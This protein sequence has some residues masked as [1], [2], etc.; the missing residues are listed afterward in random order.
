MRN[1]F[2]CLVVAFWLGACSGV[3]VY[4]AEAPASAQVQTQEQMD[5]SFFAIAQ[6]ELRANHYGLSP[7]AEQDLQAYI[8]GGTSKLTKGQNPAEIAKARGK[9][10]VFIRELMFQAKERS[11]R[12]ISKTVLDDTKSLFCPGFWPFC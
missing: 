1:G 5:A 9:F 10:G 8:H 12:M 3:A 2:V 6:A 4:S 7:E 11:E